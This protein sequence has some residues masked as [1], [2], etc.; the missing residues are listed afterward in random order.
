[1]LRHPVVPGGLPDVIIIM[2]TF[3]IIIIIIVD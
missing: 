1:V 3:I 2:F